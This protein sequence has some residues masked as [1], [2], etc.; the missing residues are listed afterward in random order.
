MTAWQ[1]SASITTL[2][3]RAQLIQQIRDFFAARH[4]LEVETPVLSTAAATDPHLHS[5]CTRSGEHTYFLQ[6]SPEFFM[7]RL[8]AA[9]SGCIFQIG[10]AFRNE[11]H[12][13]QHRAE[14]T[15]LEWYRVGFDHW[16]LM[17]EVDALLQRTLGCGAA[18]RVSYQQ[19][20]LDTLQ[21]DPFT[22]SI[23]DLAQCAQQ[24]SLDP[25]DLDKDGWLNYLMSQCIEPQLGQSQ[26]TFVYDYPA[27]QAA[28]AKIRGNVAERFEVYVQGM[29]LANGFHE[30]TDA[31]EQRQRFQQDNTFRAQHN[32]PVL[33]MDDD[34]IAA[35]N[36][37]MPASAGI[38]LG[39][40]RLLMLKL[41]I[42]DIAAVIS[43]A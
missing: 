15:M 24:H 31:Y 17:D 25:L 13:R 2:R 35:L 30:L 37:G 19:L 32:L 4:V 18:Q 6:T 20:F 16:Q 34:L 23:D 14:F 11:E 33:P 36:H 3:A 41:G 27:S 8:L 7:K 29:E 10:K 42:N 28:L 26:P 1:P 38:A 12:G 22:A 40:D 9:D 5:L 43:F 21:C 39:V